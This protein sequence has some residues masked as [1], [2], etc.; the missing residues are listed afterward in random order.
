VVVVMM[1]K[2]MLRIAVHLQSAAHHI[3]YTLHHALVR[4]ALRK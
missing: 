3:R 2:K 4:I 1:Y